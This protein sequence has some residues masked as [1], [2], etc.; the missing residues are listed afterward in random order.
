MSANSQKNPHISNNILLFWFC[1][2]V[3]PENLPGKE[4]LKIRPTHEVFSVVNCKQQVW[5]TTYFTFIALNDLYHLEWKI[6]SMKNAKNTLCSSVTPTWDEISACLPQSLLSHLNS[7]PAL[8]VWNRIFCVEKTKAWINWSQ[9]QVPERK[10][11]N[12]EFKDLIKHSGSANPP[13]INLKKLTSAK[14][15]PPMHS[16][17]IKNKL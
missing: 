5:F 11:D 8:K 14:A 17:N 13:K 6:A 7:A 3:N 4:K 9:P 15:S 10:R 1:V 16:S 2:N 12:Q